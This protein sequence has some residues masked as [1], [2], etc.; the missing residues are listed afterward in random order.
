MSKNE[1]IIL[2]FVD[3]VRFGCCTAEMYGS[4]FWV[5][6]GLREQMRKFCLEDGFAMSNFAELIQI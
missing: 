4:G 3:L 1:K 6:T 2:T 5:L